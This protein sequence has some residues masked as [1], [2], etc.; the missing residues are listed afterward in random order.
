ME[1]LLDPSFIP[2]ALVWTHGPYFV[3]ALAMVLL[4]RRLRR[5]ADRFADTFERAV[6]RQ[7]AAR[8]TPEGPT[9]P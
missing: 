9:P 8:A 7:L 2:G 5:R 1:T 4:V 3:A 6:E